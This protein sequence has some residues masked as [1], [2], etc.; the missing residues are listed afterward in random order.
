MNQFRKNGLDKKGCYKPGPTPCPHPAL[1]F[2][3][4]SIPERPK[5]KI[6]GLTITD[7]LSWDTHISN[8]VTKARRSLGYLRRAK[9]VLSGSSLAVIYK[10]HIRSIM[11]YASP[12]WMGGGSTQLQR[13]DKIQER[14]K[15]IIGPDH[16]FNLQ[17]L[18][19][20]RG[21]A[22]MCI[23]HRLARK[24]A[25]EAIHDLC[26]ERAPP[27]R[28]RRKRR[29][30]TNMNY[31]APLPTSSPLYL[32]NSMLPKLTRGWN[33][34]LSTSMQSRTSESLQQFKCRVNLISLHNI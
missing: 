33:N 21:V 19:H 2:Y 5:T 18:A 16:C 26:P 8:T 6:L 29:S 27:A 4:K 34:L 1:F 28:H 15:R 9:R 30:T 14:A 25:P 11:E 20:R 3:G 31:F 24:T 7:N 10:S 13:L 22:G 23:L 32:K 17:E 12:I